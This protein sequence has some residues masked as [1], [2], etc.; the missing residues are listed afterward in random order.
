MTVTVTETG[1]RGRG[2]ERMGKGGLMG[3]KKGREILTEKKRLQ[4]C[5]AVRCGCGAAG[6][7]EISWS[8]EGPGSQ[9]SPL[10]FDIVAPRRS[11]TMTRGPG[12]GRKDRQDETSRDEPGRDKNARSPSQQTQLVLTPVWILVGPFLEL[13]TFDLLTVGLF[14]L[15]RG[16][17]GAAG[18]RKWRFRTRIFERGRTA[19]TLPTAV[20]PQ[21]KYGAENI[22]PVGLGGDWA[23]GTGTWDW[24][25]WDWTLLGSAWMEEAHLTPKGE[26]RTKQD[27]RGRNEREREWAATESVSRQPGRVTG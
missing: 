6:M 10:L 17:S 25:D 3:L 11:T 26:R 19:A 22:G 5:S 7:E 27:G 20:S 23:W 24:D 2:R 12:E 1:H 13:W 15:G 8:G 18:R 9:W 4:R 21:K 16:L 14:D